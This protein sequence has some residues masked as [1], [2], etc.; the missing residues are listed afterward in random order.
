MFGVLCMAILIV[1]LTAEA[2]QGLAK[3]N[4]DLSNY[5]E[6]ELE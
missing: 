6:K 1:N 2:S 4:D 5:T 3:C